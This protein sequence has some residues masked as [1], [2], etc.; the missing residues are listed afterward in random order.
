MDSVSG[1][2]ATSLEDPMPTLDLANV[3]YETKGAIAY[4]TVNRPKMLN[5]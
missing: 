5:A 1:T 3:I 2:L 4:V